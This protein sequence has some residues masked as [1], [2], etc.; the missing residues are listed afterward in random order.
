MGDDRSRNTEKEE[1]DDG[2][3]TPQKSVKSRAEGRP[4]EEKSS[5]DA[6]AQAK[7]ILEE[8]EERVAERSARAEGTERS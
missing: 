7:A 4:P 6:R 2:G 1:P 5:D 8:S 3:M